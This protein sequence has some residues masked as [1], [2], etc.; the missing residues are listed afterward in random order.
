MVAVRGRLRYL[1]ATMLLVAMAL[2]W[3]FSP[4]APEHLTAATAV[5][6]GPN[7]FVFFTRSSAAAWTSLRW[8]IPSFAAFSILALVAL[9]PTMSAPVRLVIASAAL[10]V[11]VL[12]GLFAL[13]FLI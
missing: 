11:W 2:F 9:N 4:L 3:A 10:G 7:S 6:A 5:L 1:I 12:S 13:A 8:S